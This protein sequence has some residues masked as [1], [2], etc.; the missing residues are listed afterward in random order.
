MAA[1]RGFEA[2]VINELVPQP[3]PSSWLPGGERHES[4]L[5]LLASSSDPRLHSLLERRWR[6]DYCLVHPSACQ[7]ACQSVQH[8]CQPSHPRGSGAL[9]AAEQSTAQMVHNMAISGQLA[10]TDCLLL[11]SR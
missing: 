10:V 1:L 5:K 11:L 6:C 4:V 2:G 7:D 3:L 9:V 8:T